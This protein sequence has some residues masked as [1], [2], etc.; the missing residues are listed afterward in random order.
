MATTL[1]D[2]KPPLHP[3]ATYAGSGHFLCGDPIDGGLLVWQ[4][5]SLCSTPR[6]P[7][8]SRSGVPPLCSIEPTLGAVQRW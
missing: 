7:S 1:I 6:P 2:S 5:P 3:L 4:S 8:A